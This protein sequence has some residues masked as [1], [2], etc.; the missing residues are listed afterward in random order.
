MNHLLAYFIAQLF[1]GAA[2][3]LGFYLGSEVTV[4]IGMAALTAIFMAYSIG[5]AVVLLS[6]FPEDAPDDDEED[7]DNGC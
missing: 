3:G 6:S 1:I 2:M 4:Q 7:L 5:E